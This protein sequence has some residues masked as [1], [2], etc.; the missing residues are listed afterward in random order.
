MF[1]EERKYFIKSILLVSITA[2]ILV[3]ALVSVGIFALTYSR[4]DEKQLSNVDAL[5]QTLKTAELFS[6]NAYNMTATSSNNAFTAIDSYLKNADG[7]KLVPNI[8]FDQINFE[9]VPH[10]YHNNT[11]ICQESDDSG[12]DNFAERLKIL[13]GS[14]VMLYQRVNK[15]G[16]MFLICHSIR[17]LTNNFDLRYIKASNEDFSRNKLIDKIFKGQVYHSVQDL[18]GSVYSISF[19]RIIDRRGNVLGMIAVTTKLS[20]KLDFDHQYFA[21]KYYFVDS[22]TRN[23]VFNSNSLKKINPKY[24]SW[25]DSVSANRYEEQESFFN[26][27]LG[28]ACSYD[29]RLNWMILAELPQ[30]NDTLP[31]GLRA[32]GFKMAFAVGTI[33]LIL[34]III[35]IKKSDKMKRRLNKKEECLNQF[36]SNIIAG[37]YSENENEVTMKMIYGKS[38]DCPSELFELLNKINHKAYELEKDKSDLYEILDSKIMQISA[39]AKKLQVINEEVSALID[40][41]ADKF[42]DMSVRTSQI[43]NVLS[44]LSIWESFNELA[45]KL[46]V[47]A[48]TEKIRETSQNLRIKS[49]IINDKVEKIFSELNVMKK[50]SDH[51]YLVSINSA[52][53]AEKANSSKLAMLSD[54]V[55][56]LSENLSNAS[57]QVYYLLSEAKNASAACSHDIDRINEAIAKSPKPSD[58]SEM[59]V[60]FSRFNE[61]VGS[62]SVKFAGIHDEGR[63]VLK[64]IE[65]SK[66]VLN[67]A[68]PM[69]KN[70]LDLSNGI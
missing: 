2:I 17:G 51:A 55:R 60:E 35:T 25:A 6:E 56:R 63:I 29:N 36:M 22:L 12:L 46:Q 61:K 3:V 9:N 21:K 19:R 5:N 1:D 47:D 11:N 62:L 13:T 32:N 40:T 57:D 43:A 16:D 30:G 20:G 41:G 10:L 26:E 14:N 50:I 52:I 8:P 33:V 48:G 18:N 58:I 27:E 31:T 34:V 53:F 15:Q 37:K 24:L 7:F 69:I 65:S 42:S 45:A 39:F 59:V 4:P 66:T 23:I 64:T 68:I 49:G 70:L 67:K 44:D 28:L 38:S 54:E